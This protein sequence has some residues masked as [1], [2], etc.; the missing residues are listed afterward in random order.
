MF[1]SFTLSSSSKAHTQKK[2]PLSSWKS[3]EKH[4]SVVLNILDEPQIFF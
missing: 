1:V 4:G 2:K 3:A